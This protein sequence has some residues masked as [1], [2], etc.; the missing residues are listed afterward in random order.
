M[1]SSR[2]GGFPS[3]YLTRERGFDRRVVEA[4]ESVTRRERES[5]EDF[6]TRAGLHPLGSK[7]KVCGHPGQ[8]EPEP[9]CIPD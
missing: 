1:T 3:E 7:I 6:V 5:Y 4:V 8:Y 2:T 9:D